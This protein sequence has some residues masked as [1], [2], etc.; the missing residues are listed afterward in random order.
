ML[1]ESDEAIDRDSALLIRL[2]GAVLYEG[3]ILCP[4][5]P[6]SVKNRQRFTFGR[7][8][9][10][11]FSRLQDVVER[12]IE[13]PAVP[14]SALYAY[15]HEFS[16]PRSREREE[17]Q[18][19]GLLK[20]SIER[21]NE[22]IDGSVDVGVE[23]LGDGL[24]K[25]AVEIVNESGCPDEIVGSEDDAILLRMFTSTHTILRVQGGRFLSLT[26]PPA[27]HADA[28]A[29]CSNDGTWP[30]L[31]GDPGRADTLLS[32]PIIL[33]DY[34]EIAPESAGDLFDGTE[35]DEIRI[36]LALVIDDDPG[37]DLGFM[38]QPGHR[39]FYTTDEVEP[40]GEKQL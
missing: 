18:E 15:T 28:A 2:S 36:Y 35:I 25:V 26:D 1:R 20:G 40:L 23:A 22:R 19:G 12:T 10:R 7:V 8:Y 31:V 14:L 34:P 24:F 32:S 11:A 4:Y 37:K 30:V 3:H 6:S 38:R 16:I 13:L 21:C 27:E 9:P 17:L 29:A 33:Y 39:F 5:R